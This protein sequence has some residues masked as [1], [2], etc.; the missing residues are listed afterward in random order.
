MAQ[1]LHILNGDSTLKLFRQAGI[2]GAT[3]IFREILSEGPS[4]INLGDEASNSLRIAFLSKYF[5]AD[6]EAY[7]NRFTNELKKIEEENWDEI[8]LWFEYDLFCQI[9]SI[10]LLHYLCN[11]KNIQSTISIIYAGKFEHSHSLL[12]LGEISPDLYPSLFNN[13]QS[14][15]SEIKSMVLLFCELWTTGNHQELINI[16]QSFPKK[17][18]PYLNNA[19]EYHL[20]RIP[21]K[22]EIHLIEKKILAL[23]HLNE[24]SEKELTNALLKWDPYF[25]I[26][27]LSFSNYIAL[28]S[29]LFIIEDDI[30]SLNE[31][32]I[33]T[34]KTNK[35]HQQRSQA[36]SY[37]SC[38][39]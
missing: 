20:A 4:S 11:L 3:C 14:I 26:G 28:L 37:G 13:R 18:F 1:N 7:E 29:P 30:L 36:Y 31:Y 5:E 24:F 35:L 9:N 32:G 16:A 33:E 10:F 34:L 12:A 22:G 19:I 21:A 27:D 17:V 8:I 15:A 39:F 38:H 2:E 6:A 25:G 23:V